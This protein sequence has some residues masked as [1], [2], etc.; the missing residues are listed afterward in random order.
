M[1]SFVLVL[2]FHGSVGAGAFSFFFLSSCFLVI[3]VQKYEEC[4]VHGGGLRT[5]AAAS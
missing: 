4:I 2:F 1:L 5:T 3:A